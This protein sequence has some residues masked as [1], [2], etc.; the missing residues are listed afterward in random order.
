MILTRPEKWLG[1]SAVGC[2]SVDACYIQVTVTL[3]TSIWGFSAH[4]A[5]APVARGWVKLAAGGRWQAKSWS[6]FST[7]QLTDI[8]E[9]VSRI[10]HNSRSLPC[11]LVQYGPLLNKKQN[12]KKQNYVCGTTTTTHFKCQSPSGCSSLQGRRTGSRPAHSYKSPWRLCPRCQSGPL[13]AWDFWPWFCLTGCSPFLWVAKRTSAAAGTGSIS[14]S[15]GGARF[16]CDTARCRRTRAPR[17]LT[18]S[19]PSDPLSFPWQLSATSGRRS[20]AGASSCGDTDTAGAVWRRA[21]TLCWSTGRSWGWCSCWSIPAR[22]WPWT[23]S[24]RASAPGRRNLEGGRGKLL[25]LQHTGKASFHI[26]FRALAS[27]P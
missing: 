17:S 12:K 25:L 18:C 10:L 6:K 1:W 15:P 9:S 27:T 11:R 14:S 5:A 3:N 2:W 19:L 22:R 24:P 13:M 26:P 8:W 23:P 21:G 16:P 20:G 7:R 4:N